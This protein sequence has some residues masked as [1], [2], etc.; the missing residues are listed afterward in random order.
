MAHAS[1]ES[2]KWKVSLVPEGKFLEKEKPKIEEFPSY[3][4]FIKLL[5]HCRKEN[6]HCL[7]YVHGYGKSFKESLDQGYRLEKKY[8]IEVVLF[9]WPSNTG[10]IPIKEYKN[11]KRHAI[12][13]STALDNIFEKM[14]EY[15]K[16]EFNREKLLECNLTINLMTYSMGNYIFQRYIEESMYDGETNMFSNVI[17]CQADVDNYNHEYWVNNIQAGKRVYITI[18]ENDKILGWSDANFQ[19]DRLGRTAKYL[20]SKNAIYFDFTGGKNINNIH[21]L[22]YEVDGN[23]VLDNFFQTVFTGGRGES[24]NGLIFDGAK[25]SYIFK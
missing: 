15:L 7:F 14:S 25:N 6:K 3:R 8:N 18:N 12:T 13:S 22:W 19:K 1:F 2:K 9:S 4:E 16:F 23:D 21:Q 10:G 24:V 5:N 11:V 20:T 17:L